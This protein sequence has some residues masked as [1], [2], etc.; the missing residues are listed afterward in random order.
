MASSS[1]DSNLDHPNRDDSN[2]ANGGGGGNLPQQR[3]SQD[4][5][6]GWRQRVVSKFRRNKRQMKMQ[7][8]A[9]EVIPH[10]NTMGLPANLDQF[11]LDNF[12]KLSPEQLFRTLE[13]TQYVLDDNVDFLERSLE[14]P[15]VETTTTLDNSATAVV[16]GE[17][18][19][20]TLDR[21]T[22][23]AS[24][25]AVVSEDDGHDVFLDCTVAKSQ[26]L[27][28]AAA[29]FEGG[30]SLRKLVRN[31]FQNLLTNTFTDW[32]VEPPANLQ[33]R[34]SP[35]SNLFGPLLMR[36]HM[37]C[38]ARVDFDRMVFEFIRL[39][40]GSLEGNGLVLNLLGFT[41]DHSQSAGTPANNNADAPASS[42]E[43]VS[44]AAATAVLAAAASHASNNHANAT[45]TDQ[46]SSPPMILSL[47]WKEN[48]YSPRYQT[49][50]DLYA[51]DCILTQDDLFSSSCVKNGLKNLLVRILKG[52]GFRTS[53]KDVEINDISIL[54]SGKISIKGQAR[55]IG[56]VI[57]HKQ[58]FEVRTGIDFTCRG[59]VLSFPGL[60]ISLSPDVGLFVPVVP[61]LELDVGHN[62]RLR[63]IHIDG[64]NKLVKLAAS[65]KITPL[66]TRKMNQQYTQ[67][68]KSYSARFSVDVGNWLTRIGR[69]SL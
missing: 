15:L 31:W 52:R 28:E 22:T 47:L 16:I 59:H 33:V 10:K 48:A 8:V 43:S 9:D 46:A 68:P 25:A 17:D 39:S 67:S 63:E 35:A 34:V 27:G 30:S 18:E 44:A 60:E 57:S 4:N 53:R 37:H 45:Q 13:G 65:V 61:T 58:P 55:V 24:T 56:G 32:A 51:N 62:A 3:D 49:P 5:K 20:D 6:P 23:A 66:H 26:L 29:S 64:K 41:V 50:F 54:K 19:N 12:E 42:T 11:V 69:F 2:T 21:T 1:Q 40:G 7:A 36:G 14:L 38:N